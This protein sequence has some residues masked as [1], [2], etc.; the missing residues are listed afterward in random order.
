MVLIISKNTAVWAESFIYL[1]TN[2]IK[3]LIST[4][5]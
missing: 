3:L 5:G 1:T 4:G 2:Y